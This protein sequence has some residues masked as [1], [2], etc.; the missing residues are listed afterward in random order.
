M[1]EGEGENA[2]GNSGRQAKPVCV[3]RVGEGAR[4]EAVARGDIA[5]GVQ[6][7]PTGLEG[8]MGTGEGDLET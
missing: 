6:L 2:R 8:S 7:K 4:T 3:T 1:D 5:T